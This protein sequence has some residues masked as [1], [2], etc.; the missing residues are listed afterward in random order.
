M[1]G[2]AD[3]LHHLRNEKETWPNKLSQRF[4]GS[5]LGT[6]QSAIG[7]FFPLSPVLLSQKS[8]VAN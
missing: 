4:L 5:L 3:I 6:H 7:Q 1:K 2:M 8:K